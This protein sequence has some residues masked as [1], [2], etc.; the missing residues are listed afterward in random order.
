MVSERIERAQE[1]MRREGV[2]LLVVLGS[3]S[4][5][6]FTGEAREKSCL[7]IPGEGEAVLLLPE[8][9]VHAYRG[10][11]RALPYM[12]L[13][14]M[15]SQLSA[16]ASSLSS[17]PRAAVVVEAGTP[18]HLLE[19]LAN[20]LPG[21]EVKVARRIMTE[22]RMRKDR[23]ELDAVRRASKLA[24]RG[25][26]RA[27]EVI[28]PGA[29]EAQVAAEVECHLRRGGAEIAR[30]GVA[31]GTRSTSP[32]RSASDR[33][34]GRNEPVVV[35]ISLAFN[36]YFAELAR[37][38]ATGKAQEELQGLHAAYT[39]MLELAL[40]AAKLGRKAMEVERDVT[41]L[42]YERGFGELYPGGFVHGIGLSVEEAP[43]YEAY[44]EDALL[45]LVENS[46]LAV[47]HALLGRG[48]AG[49][50]LE[51]TVLLK[52]S[53]AEVLTRFPREIAEL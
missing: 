41:L 12:A 6:Y 15:L 43:H 4:Y 47:G 5:R 1:V 26:E 27:F 28:E 16:F 45:E 34:I 40:E 33:K 14:Q 32:E 46:T 11:L 37:V 31:S 44:P 36:G 20:A 13:P 39:E 10:K 9:E 48:E 50:R 18:L 8:S 52:G 2:E 23:A 42:A 35:S 7:L 38:A 24:C 25:M 19:H 17:K 29:S 53:R 21:F 22:L 51:E 30:V 3:A 49:L